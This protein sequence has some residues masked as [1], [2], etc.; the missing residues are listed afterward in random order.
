MNKQWEIDPE[1]KH[2]SPDLYAVWNLKHYF[3]ERV[4]SLNTYKS[5]FYIYTDSGAWRENS[6]TNW[7][8]QSFVQ[9]VAEK[10]GDRILY[11]QVAD[12]YQKP[13]WFLFTYNTNDYIQGNLLNHKK[14]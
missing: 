14:K 8:D 2:H 13:S 10:I 1:R 4:S 6:F 9:Q 3:L 11:G 5:K 7:P 12:T